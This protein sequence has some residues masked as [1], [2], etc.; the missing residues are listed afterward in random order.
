MMQLLLAGDRPSLGAWMA[1]P[2]PCV[3]AQACLRDI[4]QRR[5]NCGD[6]ERIHFCL[7]LAEIIARH[8]AGED[9]AMNHENL[10]AVSGSVAHRA[11]LE[12]ARGQLLIACKRRGAWTHLDRGFELAAPLLEPEAYFVVLRRHTC[13]RHLRLS[14]HGA[15]RLDLDE[16]LREAAVIMRLTGR[17]RFTR[18]VDLRH[19]DTVD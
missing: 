19:Q 15:E 14:H 10:L 16:L 5:I 12:L 9:T 11:Q 4:R 18:G 1:D 2:M 13:L 8:W 17:A 6:F 7:G 3:A